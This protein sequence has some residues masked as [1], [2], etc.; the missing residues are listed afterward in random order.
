MF[1]LQL[2]L[3]FQDVVSIEDYYAGVDFPHSTVWLAGVS[4]TTK[5]SETYDDGYNYFTPGCTVAKSDFRNEDALPTCGAW[6]RMVIGKL[7][8][9]ESPDFTVRTLEL[10]LFALSG[11]VFLLIIR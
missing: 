9:R 10:C 2:L 7:R 1:L 4:G 11:S 6:Y 8:L 3:V 5:W